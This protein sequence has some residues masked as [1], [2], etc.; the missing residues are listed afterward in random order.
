MVQQLTN[1]IR[2]HEDVGSI[3]GLAQWVK[4]LALP[5]AV[6]WVVDAA[7]IWHG[8]GCGI[9]WWLQLRLDLQPGN[10]HVLWVWP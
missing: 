9:G 3:P 8:C 1:P 10:L 7:Q 6:V 5:C 2:I 4:D